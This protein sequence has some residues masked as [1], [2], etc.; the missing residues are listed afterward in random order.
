MGSKPTKI[1]LS[2]PGSVGSSENRSYVVQTADIVE[3]NKDGMC[4]VGWK[5]VGLSPSVRDLL[6]R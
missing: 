5:L 6:V 1:E 4:L 2:D 3:N